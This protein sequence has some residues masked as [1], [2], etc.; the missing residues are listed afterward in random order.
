MLQ[1]T[2]ASRIKEVARLETARFK[3]M[4]LRL[5]YFILVIEYNR[6]ENEGEQR[7]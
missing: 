6:N 1:P 2:P 7:D 5:G 3:G 4:L